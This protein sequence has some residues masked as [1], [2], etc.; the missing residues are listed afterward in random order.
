MPTQKNFNF[1]PRNLTK[2]AIRRS[3]K[4]KLTLIGAENKILVDTINGYV[5]K[6][7]AVCSK[8]EASAEI[9]PIQFANAMAK[10]ETVYSACVK[11][12]LM[13][14]ELFEEEEMPEARSVSETT[15]KESASSSS[16]SATTEAS[17]KLEPI[18]MKPLTIDEESNRRLKRLELRFHDFVARKESAEKLAS[19]E[20]PPS[21]EL[22]FS[23]SLIDTVNKKVAE[24]RQKDRERPEP[25]FSTILD[26]FRKKAAELET[27]DV[28]PP[29]EL[30]S[31]PDVSGEL[32][33]FI[34]FQRFLHGLD[35]MD[36][37][38]RLRQVLPKK[39]SYQMT[40]ERCRKE[41]QVQTSQENSWSKFSP[42]VPENEMSSDQDLQCSIIRK[43]EHLEMAISRMSRCVPEGFAEESR[44]TVQHEGSGCKTER[45]SKHKSMGSPSVVCADQKVLSNAETQEAGTSSSSVSFGQPSRNIVLEHCECCK[46]AYAARG[47]H[48]DDSA[49]CRIL[50]FSG[51]K[52]FAGLKALP[53]KQ[54]CPICPCLH[55]SPLQPSDPS[56]GYHQANHPHPNVTL[57]RKL[58]AP[59]KD[60][61]WQKNQQP[62][63]DSA[64]PG[65]R[66]SLN[67]TAAYPD[68]KKAYPD[69]KNAHEELLSDKDRNDMI[70]KI[71]EMVSAQ[72]LPML[73][74]RTSSISSSPKFQPEG[75]S[76]LNA[77]TSPLRMLKRP[78][79]APSVKWSDEQRSMASFYGNH[80]CDN[81]THSSLCPK[82]E[83]TPIVVTQAPSP[84]NEGSLTQTS[85]LT[86]SA[87]SQI[88]LTAVNSQDS[89][90][91][92]SSQSTQTYYSLEQ[93]MQELRTSL[94]DIQSMQTMHHSNDNHAADEPY[95]ADKQPYVADKQPYVADK[96]P[97][98]ADKQPYLVNEQPYRD[99]TRSNKIEKGKSSTSSPGMSNNNPESSQFEGLRP[100]CLKPREEAYQAENPLTIE[101][102]DYQGMV[103][104]NNL[105]PGKSHQVEK[106]KESMRQHAKS[107]MQR[108]R[109]MRGYRSHSAPKVQM[110]RSQASNTPWAFKC[111]CQMNAT[112]TNGAEL[113]EEENANFNEETGDFDDGFLSDRRVHF[114]CRM[115]PVSQPGP[116]GTEVESS[117]S[118][119][120]C[121]KPI[122]SLP[123][124]RP[125]LRLVEVGR[126][127]TPIPSRLSRQ[128][129]EAWNDGV[130]KS[131]ADISYG[132]EK[133]RPTNYGGL[134]KADD[135]EVNQ[136]QD[137]YLNPKD[138]LATSE[139]AEVARYNTRDA[140]NNISLMEERDGLKKCRPK[141]TKTICISNLPLDLQEIRLLY[142]LKPHGHVTK[143]YFIK[144]R[145]T[146]E[147]Q[148]IAYI[149]FSR[150]EDAAA[151]AKA[152]HKT[153]IDGHIVHAKMHNV[154][155]K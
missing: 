123:F 4:T 25:K 142:L 96:Q 108:L 107:Q 136:S 93:Q 120:L 9:T 130:Q 79:S 66:A 104:K 119:T 113:A 51:D 126:N 78:H 92:Q 16:T 27:K 110:K 125:G 105:Y 18:T 6:A 48:A 33:N 118:N 70:G 37:T 14:A 29:K 1:T 72:L 26:A 32:D 57:N 13:T 148:G 89:Q 39:V 62:I 128:L 28:S 24:L 97:Y 152:I 54:H 19:R 101:I 43:L 63:S 144:H 143:I 42:G 135:M 83:T 151:A 112:E 17:E 80:G 35:K 88:F 100:D 82:A 74:E 109:L 137:G 106:E 7:E 59:V 149:K 36:D 76:V 81:N 47:G 67:T 91:M 131:I 138:K 87:A 127:D 5:Q 23:P 121:K 58:G 41:Q 8:L 134:V 115:P 103:S 86:H 94:K 34:E 95:V 2:Q 141:S 53:L 38:S 150:E 84:A 52:T 77:P 55:S 129:P 3:L 50:Q 45:H 68:T 21:P 140:T 85:K 56:G 40:A 114:H 69:T 46:N 146:G 99:E 116:D 90:Q 12:I 44:Q 31:R 49:E 122:R 145:T 133:R 147:F 75:N 11:L 61:P 30:I 153:D 10:L 60:T 73:K 132:G 65:T 139:D 102:H 155:G 22:D 124:K 20:R 98:V 15:T 111:K 154:Q 64:T 71:V 117:S